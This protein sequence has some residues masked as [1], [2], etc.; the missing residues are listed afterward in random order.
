MATISHEYESEE[1]IWI[2]IIKCLHDKLR[3]ECEECADEPPKKRLKTW[4]T[5]LA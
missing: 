4:S 1:N 5:L 2:E 3:N